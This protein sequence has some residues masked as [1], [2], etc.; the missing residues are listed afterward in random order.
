[1]SSR[2]DAASGSSAQSTPCE[3]R[4]IVSAAPM[5]LASGTTSTRPDGRDA[6]DDGTRGTHTTRDTVCR[7]SLPAIAR[8]S[9]SGVTRRS[10]S[11]LIVA[12]SSPSG[13]SSRRSATRSDSWP[14]LS[15]RNVAT[16]INSG[17]AARSSVSASIAIGRYTTSGSAAERS[18]ASRAPMTW[19][20]ASSCAG[21][22]SHC[23]APSS[24]PS[25]SAIRPTACDGPTRNSRMPR[26]IG[27][28]PRP[29]RDSRS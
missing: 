15:A 21:C 9:T 24:A 6:D 17:V 1:M 18:A 8:W 3:S 22:S 25:G 29:A 26:N 10:V 7:R 20:Q 23:C 16:H 28:N 11:P 4:V 27:P 14:F 19:K 5:P 12:T 13:V 2:N